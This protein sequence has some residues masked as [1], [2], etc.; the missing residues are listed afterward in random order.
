M[1][2]RKGWAG[3]RVEGT[4]TPGIWRADGPPLPPELAQAYFDYYRYTHSLVLLALVAAAL[5]A[6]GRRGWLWPLVPYGLHI[7]MDIPTHER[8]RPPFLYPLSSWTFSG[9]SWGHPLI[10]FPNWIALVAVHVWLWRKYRPRHET[11]T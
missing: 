3:L 9:L 7:L 1:L 11:K 10:F 5:W 6:L 2:L 8:F 4:Q